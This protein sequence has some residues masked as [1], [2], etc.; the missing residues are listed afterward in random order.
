MVS[1]WHLEGQWRKK[2]DPDPGSGSGSG[3]IS[4][5]HGSADPDPL[6]N[7]MDTEHWLGVTPRPRF[8]S[9]WR[10]R[11]VCGGSST[12]VPIFMYHIIIKNH[13]RVMR[14]RTSWYHSYFLLKG[15]YRYRRWIMKGGSNSPSVY[16]HLSDSVTG[17]SQNWKFDLARVLLFWTVSY[18]HDTGIRVADSHHF[19]ADPDPSYHFYADPDLHFHTAPD[20]HHDQSD[21]NLRPLV[22][23]H[24]KAP[25][26]AA[27]PPLWASTAPF[28][29]SEVSEFWLQ[30]GSGSS[31]SFWCWSGSIFLF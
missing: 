11:S 21:E 13:T 12:V 20:H 10:F 19:C 25:F 28:W 24:S 2:Q 5:R 17:F 27:T 23:R 6:Q 3:S 22:Y 7:V 26:W 15:R 9:V 14:Y 29:A 4:Q 8:D 30:C 18:R 16:L 31:F 1:C